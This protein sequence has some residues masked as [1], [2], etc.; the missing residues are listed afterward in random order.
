MQAPLE[1]AIDLRRKFLQQQND[2]IKALVEKTDSLEKMALERLN[3]ISGLNEEKRMIEQSYRD[4]ETS[5]RQVEILAIE[6]MDALT[7]HREEI[8]RYRAGLGKAQ[9]LAYER[10]DKI[11][12]LQ[13]ENEAASLEIDRL[14]ANLNRIKNTWWF[15]LYHRIGRLHR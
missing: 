6:R 5:Y 3:Q 12:Q 13:S 7:Q 11:H 1:L 9:Q 8:G 14:A 15:R 10:L 4:L 2:L